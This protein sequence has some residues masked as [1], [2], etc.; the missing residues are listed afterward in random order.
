MKNYRGV[1]IQERFVSWI[2]IRSR[3]IM[4]PDRFVLRGWIR[5]QATSDRIRKPPTLAQR[6]T[7]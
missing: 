7:H 3:K 5:I 1:L 6:L 4:D 2:R